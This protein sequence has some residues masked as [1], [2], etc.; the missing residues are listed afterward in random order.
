MNKEILDGLKQEGL[1]AIYPKGTKISVQMGTCGRASGADEIYRMLE[2]ELKDSS[3]I[4]KKTGCLGLCEREPMLNVFIPGQNPVVYVDLKPKIVAELLPFWKKG[5]T[6]EKNSLM[7]LNGKEFQTNK[8]GLKNAPGIKKYNEI[9]FYKNQQKIVL[10]NCGF[11]DPDNIAEYVARGG[12]SVLYDILT[13]KKPE[14]VIDTVDSSGLRGRGGGG[15]P[16]GKKWRTCRNVPAKTRYVICNADEGDPGAYMDRTIIEGDPFRVLEG[17]IIGAYAVGSSNGYIYVRAEYPQAVET[18]KRSINILRENSL[19]GKHIF[20]SDFSFDIQINKGGGAFVCGES[21]ALMASIEGKVGEP[22]TKHIHTVVSGLHDCPTVL[23]N[24]E[25]WGNVPAI[26]SMGVNNYTKMGTKG[27]KGT[28][29][30]SVV[31]NVMNNGLVEVPMG[32]S[33]NEIVND[34][35]GGVPEGKKLKAVQTGGPSGG[36]IPVALMDTPVDF[37]ELTKLGSMMGSG[38]LIVMDENSCMVEVARYF[39]SFLVEESC[40][41]C[42][43]CREGNY[44]LL[45][46][47]ERLTKGEARSDDMETLEELCHTIQN[48]SLCALGKSAPSPVLSTIKYFRKEYEE[49]IHDKKCNAGVCKAL[50]EYEISTENC[51]GCK[52]CL[53]NCP[54]EAITGKKDEVHIIHKDKCTKCG[55]CFDVCTFD[56][57]MKV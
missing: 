42:T 32:M 35:A 18:L 9:P 11:I 17:M 16:A 28:K 15:F 24:V 8:K 22:R 4:L 2:K 53:K 38:G 33:L 55:I 7:Q 26:F 20:G 43:P 47:L 36:C 56:A 40:G 14:D 54:Y 3:I 34:V 52:L 30:F 44:Q 21:T 13:N 51:T 29:V 57:V 31:G 19:L 46:I 1:K 6:P 49:H 37:D 27:S 50:F 45:K 25:T 48:A 39:L 12:F 10:G 5:E 23:N 41:K